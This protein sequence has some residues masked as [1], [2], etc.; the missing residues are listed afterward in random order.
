MEVLT[1]RE[2]IILSALVMLDGSSGGAPIRKKII[3]LTGKEIVYGTLYNLLEYLI[4]KGYVTTH[5]S[6]P[7]PVQG[8]RSKTIYSITKAGKSALKETMALHENIR[9]RLNNIEFEL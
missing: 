3:E 2:E 1:L 5:K 8:G 7:I 4:R 6:E 9:G